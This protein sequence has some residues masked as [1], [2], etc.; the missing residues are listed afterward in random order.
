MKD[1]KPICPAPILSE[2]DVVAYN[3]SLGANYAV[4]A[5]MEGYHVLVLD[6]YSSALEVLSELK[7]QL[8][9]QYQSKSFQ[10]Q[11]DFRHAFKELSN[12]LMVEVSE[13]KLG[14]KKAPHIGWIK[15]LY[16]DLE[17]FLLPF[18][19]VQGLNSSWQWYMKGIHIP[20]LEKK[21]YPWYGSYFPTRF[22]HIELFAD[23]LKEYKG[24]KESAIDIGIGSGILSLLLTKYGFENVIGTD[25]NPNAIIGLQEFLP[26]EN[27]E[28]KIKLHYGDLFD[29]CDEKVD[30]IVFNPPWL[31]ISRDIEGIDRAMYYD[32][33]LFPRFFD[34]ASKYLKPKGKLLIIFSNLAQITQVSQNHPI[35]DELSK[36]DRF[37]KVDLLKKQVRTA[38]KK[39]KRDLG[40]R[41]QEQ[42]EL[43]VLE[44]KALT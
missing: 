9:K 33:D 7:S 18:P 17:E 16:P 27:L 21:I 2:I 4:E 29:S 12:K 28:K 39:T 8:K 23:W 31:P 44:S 10:S 11:Q 26:K 15:I 30:I 38:S 6:Y 24:E 20:G 22:E 14:V 19:A 41:A 35:E 32:E 34:Q 42:V 5:L 13:H 3:Y 36:F 37:Q 43:W 25:T 40:R 1:I